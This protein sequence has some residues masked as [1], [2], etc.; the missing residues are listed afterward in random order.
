MIKKTDISGQWQLCLDKDGTLT[1]R[2]YSD[3]IMLPGS[4]SQQKKGEEN[5]KYE[6][7]FLTDTY[8]FEG[9][10]YFAKS[11]VIEKANGKAFLLLERTRMSRLYID[12]ELV[13]K[14]DSLNVCHRFD[15]TRFADG[16][17]HFVEICITNTGY[18]TAGGHLTSQDTQ[19]NWNGIT[20]RMEII[21]TG[22]QYLKDVMLFPDIHTGI[23]KVKGTLCGE[24]SVSAEVS[25]Q[26]C[27]S[28]RTHTPDKQSFEIN[29]GSF[30]IGYDMGRDFLLWS[31][32]TPAFYTMTIAIGEDKYSFCFGMR[33]FSHNGEKF[34]I[35]GDVTFLRGKH[36]GLI[37]P[38]T[39]FAPTDVDEWVRI[40]EISKSYG[41][42]H[43]RF[44]TCCPPEAAFEA[45]DRVGIYFEPQLPFWG[46]IQDEGE[47]GFN[48]EEQAYLIKEGYRILTEFGSHPSF[49]M[50]SLGNELWGSQKRLNGFLKDYKAFDNRH[51]Y[52]QGSNNFQWFPA[53][54]E[55]DD[56]FVGVRLANDRLLR[57]SYAMCDAPQGHIQTSRPSTMTDYDKAVRPEKAAHASNVSDDG[58]VQIQYGTT[59]KTVKASDADADFIPTV[60]I[61]TH[62]IGQYE[63]F[64]DL[65]EIEKYT[66][67]VKARNFETFRKTLEKKGLLKYDRD[68]FECSGKLAAACYKEELEAVFRSRTLAGCQIL[69][70]QDFSGQ[71]TALV[72]ML[73]AFMDSKGLVSP[74]EYRQFCSDAVIMA[75]F[76]KYVYAA[77]EEFKAHI[78]LAYFRPESIKGRSCTVSLKSKQ[79]ELFKKSFTI[80]GSG[81]YYDIADIEAVFPECEVPVLYTLEISADGTD[82][83][84][85]YRLSVYPDADISGVKY[86]ESLDDAMEKSGSTENV[87][88]I[89]LPD[90][91]KSIEGTYCTDFWCYPMFRSIS[92]MMKKPRPIGTMGLMI[93]K[94]SKALGSFLSESYSTPDWYDIVSCS[95]S[96]I[97]DE[98]VSRSVIVRTIDNFERANSLALLYEYEYMDKKV[99]RLCADAKKLTQSL[100]GKWLISQLAEYVKRS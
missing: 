64:P 68:F 10:A 86:Y 2:V 39:G 99:L 36:D 8:K 74:Q 87:L 45:A 4:T 17:E 31:E 63:T 59:M 9:S 66:G 98:D 60:P 50:F 71:G 15:I 42:N 62:E 97:V 46:T 77:G 84:N 13:G 90:E 93:D 22:K 49:C 70:L 23:V 16:R 85:T 5:Q 28:D 26:S 14:G 75:R 37:F 51:L 57:G 55:E 100:A 34:T 80:E 89:S 76:E 69:D 88:V 58:T 67:S 54:L 43:Y 32:Y 38:K 65:N 91:D 82:I 94:G 3:T 47:E 61:V 27:N 72:G 25:A 20:G 21:Y 53:Q 79:D 18:P 24:G 7:G 96:E 12:G 52:T 40:L 1:K 81:N 33:E 35:N 30:E 41:I 92:D 29:A 11:I 95:R 6:T 73:D 19:T 48:A 56:F 83:K 44:H 78:E